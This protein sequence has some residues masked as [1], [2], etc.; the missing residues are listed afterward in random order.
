MLLGLLFRWVVLLAC[1]ISVLWP[2]AWVAYAD[3]SRSS[4]SVEVR[5]IW[6]VYDESLSYVPPAFWQGI[7]RLKFL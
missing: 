2:A 3:K 1:K 5:R 7:R 6:E 4:K